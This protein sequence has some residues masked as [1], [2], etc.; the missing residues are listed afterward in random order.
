MKRVIIFAVLGPVLGMLTGFFV[1]LPIVTVLAGDRVNINTD[2]APL[3][4]LFPVAYIVG[5]LPA[6]LVGVFDGVLANRNIGWRVL[7]SGFFGF[8]MAFLPLLTSLSMGFI[9]G[10]FVLMFGAIGALPACVCSWIAGKAV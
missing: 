7:W 8:A 6:V 5:L 4:A 1:L 9:H 3:A 10:P 2:L